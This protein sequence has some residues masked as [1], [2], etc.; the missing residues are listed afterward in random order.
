M[1]FSDGEAAKSRAESARAAARW[2]PPSAAPL[3][4]LSAWENGRM[5]Y[6]W[7]ISHD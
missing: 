1:V 2:A 4:V 7:L 3:S 5:G 6:E